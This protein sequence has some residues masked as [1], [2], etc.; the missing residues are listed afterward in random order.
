MLYK[1]TFLQLI[2]LPL[3]C[4]SGN[5]AFGQFT[6]KQL[7]TDISEQMIDIDL[8]NDGELDIISIGYDSIDGQPNHL[9]Y[10]E[11]S[12]GTFLEPVSIGETSH[13]RNIELRKADLDN[14]GFSDLIYF[15]KTLGKVN[16]YRNLINGSLSNPIQL[17]S[18]FPGMDGVELTDMD[19][20]D[21]IDI[22]ASSLLTDEIVWFKNL[23]RKSVV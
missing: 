1:S 11:N 10:F 9:Y 5:I 13:E 18:Q 12:S 22:V 2:I 17:V 21:L 8:N 6:T 4:L 15:D 23:D 14:D 19:N 16:L 20:D 7:T 3:I